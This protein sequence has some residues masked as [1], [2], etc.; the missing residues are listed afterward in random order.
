MK[1]LRILVDLHSGEQLDIT[2][3]NVDSDKFH[4]FSLPAEGCWQGEMVGIHYTDDFEV[5][6]SREDLED[7]YDI[8]HGASPSDFI[9]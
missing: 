2:T 4:S 5:G 1:V 6:P 9:V 8:Y 7:S 3:V